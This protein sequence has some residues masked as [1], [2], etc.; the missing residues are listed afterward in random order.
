M[1]ASILQLPWEDT[2]GKFFLSTPSCEDDETLLFQ[3]VRII[4]LV[5]K[6]LKSEKLYV[7]VEKLLTDELE[8]LPNVLK[9]FGKP[10]SSFAVS[11]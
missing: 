7:W 1:S 11:I 4:R 9:S 5:L 3:V 10:G 2:F 8:I 6:A